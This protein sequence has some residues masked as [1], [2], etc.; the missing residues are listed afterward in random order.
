MTGALATEMDLGVKDIFRAILEFLYAS[1]DQPSLDSRMIIHMQKIIEDFDGLNQGYSATLQVHVTIFQPAQLHVEGSDIGIVT[2]SGTY[3]RRIL[4]RFLA[5]S[6]ILVRDYLWT[7]DGFFRDFRRVQAAVFIQS[8]TAAASALLP[9]EIS[10]PRVND[11]GVFPALF[12]K[13]PD[14]A[15]NFTAVTASVAVLFL[16]VFAISGLVVFYL[17][18]PKRGQQQQNAIASVTTV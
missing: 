14:G 8:P 12:I 10:R 3:Q 2:T 13:E 7:A 4:H 6:E 18:R 17:R 16:F 15:L 11:V 9:T 5:E 1:T